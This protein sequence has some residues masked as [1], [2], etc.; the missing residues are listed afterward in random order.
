MN[1]CKS[2]IFA[3]SETIPGEDPA[4][5]DALKARLYES[6]QPTAEEATLVDAVARADWQL[7]RFSRVEAQIWTETIQTQNRSRAP[8]RSAYMYQPEFLDRLYRQQAS[9]ARTLRNSLDSLLR[10]RKLDVLQ[11]TGPNEPNLP[12]GPEPV[13]PPLTPTIDAS[14]ETNPIPSDS[15]PESA[16]TNPIPEIPSPSPQPPLPDSAETKLA[17]SG[18]C[19]S[20]PMKLCEIGFRPD[21]RSRGSSHANVR[22][23]RNRLMAGPRW[24]ESSST[25]N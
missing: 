2:G 5:L 24:Q 20:P 4:E 23:S 16:E 7:R 22:D 13:A 15:A 14:A 17:I 10:L 9:T 11:P 19:P 18:V 12:S 8:L 25:G 21:Y 1:A 3:Q 6:I